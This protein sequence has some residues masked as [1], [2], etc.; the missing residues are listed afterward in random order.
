[1]KEEHIFEQNT[2]FNLLL[3]VPIR[4]NTFEQLILIEA[5]NWD[6]ETKMNKL[7]FSIS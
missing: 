5:N 7:E 4:N 3:E 2:F 1:M 6:V